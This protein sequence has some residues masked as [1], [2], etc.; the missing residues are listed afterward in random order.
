MLRVQAK[1]ISSSTLEILKQEEIGN[2]E[3]FKLL[4]E[5]H[6]QKLLQLTA[7]W[8]KT[9]IEAEADDFGSKFGL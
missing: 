4:H 8:Q 5:E 3:V 9:C 1:G 2:L 7:E 6:L